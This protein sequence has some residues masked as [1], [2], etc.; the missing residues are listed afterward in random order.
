MRFED[1]QELYEEMDGELEL[2]K[3]YCNEE[4]LENLPWEDLLEIA[5]DRDEDVAASIEA[6]EEFEEGETLDWFELDS[7]DD[8]DQA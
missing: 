7:E 3:A 2:V 6:N 4:E 8:S 5:K 1:I